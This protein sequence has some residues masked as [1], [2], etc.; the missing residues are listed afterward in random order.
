MPLPP[1]HRLADDGAPLLHAEL[2][3]VLEEHGV[4]PGGRGRDRLPSEAKVRERRGGRAAVF[5][6]STLSRSPPTHHTPPQLHDYLASVTPSRAAPRA[7]LHA[8][9]VACAA[10]GLTRTEAAALA[11]HCPSVEVDVYA[12]VPDLDTRATE[13]AAP[14][15]TA[16][17]TLVAASEACLRDARATAAAE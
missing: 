12:L 10:A 7:A 3:H 1:L 11:N 13:G 15:L 5:R 4:A 17:A 6:F 14:L 8:F 9:A 2:L 16:V